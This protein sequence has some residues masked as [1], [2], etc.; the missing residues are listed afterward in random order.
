MQIILNVG[1]YYDDG[2]GKYRAIHVD[3]MSRTNL[4]LNDNTFYEALYAGEKILGFKLCNMCEE[5]EDSEI[6][7]DIV[8]KLKE[9]GFQFEEYNEII[10]EDCFI[11]NDGT[12]GCYPE[13]FAII[14][15]FIAE[16]GNPDLEFKLC[17]K[18]KYDYHIGGYGLF[19]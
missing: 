15:T 14:A 8:I 1:D 18:S 7:V 12:Y 5:H 13:G 11:Y 4:E 19:Y 3:M 10:N 9:Y 17:K 2:H 16:L 6:P